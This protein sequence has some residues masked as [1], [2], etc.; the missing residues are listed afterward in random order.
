MFDDRL[1]ALNPDNF[2]EVTGDHHLHMS[3]AHEVAKEI[4][5]FINLTQ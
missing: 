5:Q 3:H 1:K 4:S 2:L